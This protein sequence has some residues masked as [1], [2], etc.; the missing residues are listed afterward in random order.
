MLPLGGM[1]KGAGLYA[2]LVKTIKDIRY[3]PRLMR[4]CAV[5][6]EL[7]ERTKPRRDMTQEQIAAIFLIDARTLRT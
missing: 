3:K 6:A 5:L 1:G 4:T 2:D 7:T